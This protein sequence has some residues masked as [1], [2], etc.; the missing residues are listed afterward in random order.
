MIRPMRP[1]RLWGVLRTLQRWGRSPRGGRDLA[2]GALPGRDDDRRRARHAHLQRGRQRTNAL[3]HALSDAGHRRGR[4]RG[5]HVPQPPRLHR[6]DRRAV[7][8][9]RRRALPE[10][11]LRRA[12][13][14]P[15]WCSA[16]SRRRSSS[17]R[18]STSCSRTPASAASASWPGT[19]RRACPD[20]TLDELIGGRATRATVVPP[21]REGRAVILTSGTTG[22]PKGA[23]RGNPQSLDPVVALSVADPAEGPAA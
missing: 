23:S 12:R 11:R 14:S 4:R 3:A 16:R 19:T 1:D 7:E 22:T 13:S 17:T 10:H 6:G 20:P 18:S 9:R 2:R 15:R 5:R 21:E 8:A